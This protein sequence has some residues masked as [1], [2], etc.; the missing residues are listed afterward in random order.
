M[1]QMASVG[2]QLPWT[3]E[4]TPHAVLDLLRGCN[5]A[6]SGCYNATAKF[7]PKPF[8]QIRAELR[9]LMEL[10]RLHTVSLTGGEAL[11]HPDLDDIIRHVKDCGLRA[12]LMT[13]GVLFDETRA[14]LLKTAGLDMVVLHIQ[15]RQ[16]RPDIPQESGREA[17]STLRCEKAGIAAATGLDA[18]FSALMYPDAAGRAEIRDL[19][20]EIA[21]SAAVHFIMICP[22]GDFSI[23]SNLKGDIGTGYCQPHPPTGGLSSE[24]NIAAQ[25]EALYGILRGA[26]FG[27]FAWIGSS[28]TDGE[29]R[30]SAWNAG[31]LRNTSDVR[32]IPIYPAWTDRLLLRLVR[33]ISGRH[34]FHSRSSTARFRFQLAL[35][36]LGQGWRGAALPLLAGSFRPGA[37]LLRKH[38]VVEL[39]PS[40]RQ[41]GTVVICGECPDA[42]ILNGRLVPPCLADRIPNKDA[43]LYAT[44]IGSL[45]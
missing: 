13:N 17:I 4:M 14:R 22:Q 27:L 8:A 25:A 38:V 29:P 18:G 37:R 34:Q 44:K 32:V 30:W 24:E 43:E 41:D 45:S 23:F 5:I 33:L 2:I 28:S 15:D 10:R 19:L 12:V 11:L 40:Q 6:C 39:P 20:E 16:N 26:G 3:G 7:S 31:V 35:S 36:L 9:Q 21:G 42:T 1:K